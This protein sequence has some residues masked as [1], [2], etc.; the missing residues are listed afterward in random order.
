MVIFDRI[1]FGSPAFWLRHRIN[2]IASAI[3]VLFY[4]ARA[5][6]YNSLNLRTA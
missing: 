1:S 6:M 5:T 4:R 3:G 2:K